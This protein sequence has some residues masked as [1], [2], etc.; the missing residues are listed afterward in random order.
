MLQSVIDALYLLYLLI[1]VSY[2]EENSIA[3]TLKKIIVF[4]TQPGSILKM[5]GNMNKFEMNFV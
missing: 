5:Y 3:R 1:L 2:Q 4:P